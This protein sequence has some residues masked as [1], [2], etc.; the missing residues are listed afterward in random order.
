VATLE[1][2]VDETSL[3]EY[4]IT[5]PPLA[6]VEHNVRGSEILAERILGDDIG[7]YGGKTQ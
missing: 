4:E 5:S 1:K 2:Y 6:T 7:D 3:I